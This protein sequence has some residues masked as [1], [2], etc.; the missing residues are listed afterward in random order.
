MA[1]HAPKYGRKL[2]GS[3]K[4]MKDDK[5]EKME[6]SSYGYES[7]APLCFKTC[8]CPAPYYEPAEKKSASAYDSY[9]TPAAANAVDSYY[10]D[11]S[12]K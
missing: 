12:T 9:S 3:K 2:A 4:S 6:D 10:H 1:K 8:A 7:A 5:E 11:V